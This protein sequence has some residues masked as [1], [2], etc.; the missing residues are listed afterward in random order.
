MPHDLEVVNCLSEPIG[1]K[2][3]LYGLKDTKTLAED[4]LMHECGHMATIC[5][6]FEYGQARASNRPTIYYIL[7]KTYTQEVILTS[8]SLALQLASFNTSNIY[9][10]IQI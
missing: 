6:A 2:Q 10:E 1:H 9:I 3:P 4:D 7:Q 5:V 8:F